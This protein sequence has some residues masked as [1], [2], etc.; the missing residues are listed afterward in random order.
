MKAFHFNEFTKISLL[1]GISVGG[2]AISQKQRMQK[3]VHAMINPK[4]EVKVRRVIRLST[5]ESVASS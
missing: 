1:D 3:G 5:S 2:V 4:A